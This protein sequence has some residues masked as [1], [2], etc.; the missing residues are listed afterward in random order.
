MK[1]MRLVF[2]FLE[3]VY[4]FGF[5]V[6]TL[7]SV[8][9]V[10]MLVWMTKLYIKQPGEEASFFSAM[11]EYATKTNDQF[12]KFIFSP[13]GF[14]HLIL[15]FVLAIV[16]AFLQA[17]TFTQLHRF[18]K[19]KI[20]NQSSS[21]QRKQLWPIPKYIL[22]IYVLDFVL[23]LD[24]L[25]KAG[26]S[27]EGSKLP[28]W[29]NTLSAGIDVVFPKLF[30]SLG[31]PLGLILALLIYFYCQSLEQSESLS[32]EAQKLREEADLVI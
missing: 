27:N 5:A 17:K 3:K 32:Q 16:L 31:T 13:S 24:N 6:T 8:L 14:S 2:S 10:S 25:P 7:A 19:A 11:Y 9:A 1:K 30:P 28:E 18:M 15:V 23:A 21:E 26:V 12:G 20:G 4:W 29:L 22:A